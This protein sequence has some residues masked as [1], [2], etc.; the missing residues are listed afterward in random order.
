VARVGA[1]AEAAA[2]ATVVEAEAAPAAEVPVAEAIAAEAM[3]VAAK[4]AAVPVVAAL[5]AVAM[6]AVA[7]VAAAMVAAAMAAGT[8]AP[9]A[10][11]SGSSLRESRRA[12]QPLGTA[13]F[14]T[15]EWAS[16]R[17]ALTRIGHLGGGFVWLNAPAWH[18]RSASLRNPDVAGPA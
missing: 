18:G 16:V 11:G 15:T 12:G 1:E 4:A 5:V 13:P 10:A 9:S 8:A 3:A 6:V 14:P 17:R 7:T 2:E